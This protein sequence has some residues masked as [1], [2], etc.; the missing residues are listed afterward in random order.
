MSQVPGIFWLDALSGENGQL[1]AVLRY[2]E[3]DTGTDVEYETE[4]LMNASA[5]WTKTVIQ[6]VKENLQ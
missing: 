3:Y 5:A 6:G 4:D 1:R 2:V